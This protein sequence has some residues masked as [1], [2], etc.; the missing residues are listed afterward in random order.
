MSVV[1]GPLL[2][3]CKE[4]SVYQGKQADMRCWLIS[5]PSSKHSRTQYPSPPLTST[6][7]LPLGATTRMTCSPSRIV[8]SSDNAAARTCLLAR[9]IAKECKHDGV[10]RWAAGRESSVGQSLRR[11]ER[12]LDADAV[13]AMKGYSGGSSWW[14][15]EGCAGPATRRRKVEARP[16]VSRE[17]TGE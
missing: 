8:T 14:G 1:V 12:P 9:G 17:V 15:K 3:K 16:H 13:P 2:L 4:A 7:L 11:L 10:R 5:L 6:R